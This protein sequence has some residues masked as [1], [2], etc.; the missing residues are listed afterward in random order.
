M[1]ESFYLIVENL[2]DVVPIGEFDNWDEARKE[3]QSNEDH[4]THGETWILASGESL[5]KIRQKIEAE[6]ET[7]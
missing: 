5:R 2:S 4:Y 1:K 7:Y 3:A 6:L